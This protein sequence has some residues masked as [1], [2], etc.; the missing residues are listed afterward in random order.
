MIQITHIS[1]RAVTHENFNRGKEVL[2]KNRYYNLGTEQLSRDRS[3]KCSFCFEYES[4]DI[5]H[6]LEKNRFFTKTALNISYWR[7]FFLQ[8]TI[9]TDEKCISIPYKQVHGRSREKERFDNSHQRTLWL[10]WRGWFRISPKRPTIK[11]LK[12]NRR[13]KQTILGFCTTT[14]SHYCE[15]IFY[16][17]K[18]H[19]PS[20]VLHGFSTEWSFSCSKNSFWYYQVTRFEIIVIK[21]NWQKK[22]ENGLVKRAW[23]A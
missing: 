21:S 2:L 10:P 14:R 7:P 18:W 13:R 1:P 23:V 8:R 19:W 15:Q 5:N 9:R 12:G 16:H 20:I 3:I 11:R 6:L 22:H 17:D 4:C